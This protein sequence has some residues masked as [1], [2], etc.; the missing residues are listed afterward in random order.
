MVLKKLFERIIKNHYLRKLKKSQKNGNYRLTG[1]ITRISL[2]KGV[3]NLPAFSN[4]F[5][6]TGTN[7]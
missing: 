6:Q 7:V 2:R 5:I 3:H 4:C 1:Y